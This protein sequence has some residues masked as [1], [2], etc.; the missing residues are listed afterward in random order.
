MLDIKTLENWLWEANYCRYLLWIGKSYQ[1]E[2]RIFILTLQ[3][4]IKTTYTPDFF[5]E[6][7]EWHELKGWENRSELKKWKLFQEQYPIEKF[8]LIDRNKYKELERL[9]QYIIPNWEF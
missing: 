3:K 2:P 7:I 8:V 6:G 4:G 1:Y 5:V 9:Y